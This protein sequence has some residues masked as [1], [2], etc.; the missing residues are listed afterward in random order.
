[1]GT[2]PI[3]VA[4]ECFFRPRK[5]GYYFIEGM[6]KQT[7]APRGKGNDD[8]WR[9]YKLWSGD[10]WECPNCHVQ[11][12]VGTAIHPVAEQHEPSFARDVVQFGA[13]QLIVKDC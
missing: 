10:L 5:N 11:I 1:M 13:Q 9:P 12:V 2:K 3:C 4:C 8:H 7:L 6:P